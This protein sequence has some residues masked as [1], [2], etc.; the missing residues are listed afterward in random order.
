LGLPQCTGRGIPDD[1][2]E[3]QRSKN[4]LL[5]GTKPNTMS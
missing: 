1:G 4:K 2:G 3:G 5:H